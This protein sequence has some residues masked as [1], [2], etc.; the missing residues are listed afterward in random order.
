MVSEVDPQWGVVPVQN[1]CIYPWKY[2][3]VS[4]YNGTVCDKKDIGVLSMGEESS[5][6]CQ[7]SELQTKSSEK[8]PKHLQE[9]CLVLRGGWVGPSGEKSFNSPTEERPVEELETQE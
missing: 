2:K 9:D 6:T 7:R 1:G 3:Y 8:K 4:W 5:D